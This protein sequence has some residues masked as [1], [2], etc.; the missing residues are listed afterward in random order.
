[1]T[2]L[3]EQFG[4]VAKDPNTRVRSSIAAAPVP[5]SWR[6]A[7]SALDPLRPEA[8]SHE[9]VCFV[10]LC[11]KCSEL[12][13]LAKTF[14]LPKPVIA[15]FTGWRT[16]S[17]PATGRDPAICGRPAREDRALRRRG[18]IIGLSSAPETKQWW[19]ALPARRAQG[20]DGDAADRRSLIDA[21]TARAFG[22][23]HRVVPQSG[24][25]RRSRR[26]DSARHRRESA[27]APLR[28][29]RKAF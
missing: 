2:A 21:A 17:R 4:R 16:A 26:A 7:M 24:R 10:A 3:I 12:M 15:R 6:R 8:R 25:A 1:M 18:S 11:Q 13:L 22:S 19:G 27:R 29:A 9:H 14:R 28:S 23:S 20:G 5:P